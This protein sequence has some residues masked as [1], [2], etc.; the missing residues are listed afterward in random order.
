MKKFFAMLGIFVSNIFALSLILLI[1]F[2]AKAQAPLDSLFVQLEQAKDDTSKCKILYSIGWH[3]KDHDLVEGFVYADSALQL[4]KASNH[5]VTEIKTLSLLGVL[6]NRNGKIDDA[7]EYANQTYE[8]AEK[9]D[10]PVMM[11]SA[12][13]ELGNITS[14]IGDYAKSLEYFDRCLQMAEENG[15]KRVSM[16]ANLNKAKIYYTIAKLDEAI[17]SNFD[18]IKIAKELKNDLVLASAYLNCG[19]AYNAVEDYSQAIDMVTKA[20][21]LS[22]EIHYEM[23]RAE[24][25]NGLASIHNKKEDFKKGFDYAQEA[26]EIMREMNFVRGEIFCMQNLSVGLIGEGKIEEAIV[27]MNEEI[28]LCRKID[29]PYGVAT[30]LTNLGGA[31]MELGKPQLGKVYIDSA[32]ILATQI[33]ATV[34]LPDIYLNLYLVNDALKDYR[35]AL[36]YYRLYSELQ[37]SIRDVEMLREIGELKIKHEV[38]EKD[39]AIKLLEERDLRQALELE[40]SQERSKNSELK[41]SKKS[42]LIFG[43][44]AGIGLL[45]VLTILFGIRQRSRA[46]Y[47]MI[48]YERDKFEL[49]QKALRAQMNP[50][51]TFNTLN[52][53]QGYISEHNKEE[54]KHYLALFSSLMRSILINSERETISISEEVEV[55]EKYLSLEKMRFNSVFNY[56]IEIDDAIDADF[57]RIPPMLLQ[58]IVENSI[59]HGLFHKPEGGNIRISIQEGNNELVFTVEDDGIGVRAS[60]QIQATKE[61]KGTGKGLILIKELINRKGSGTKGTL[62]VEDLTNNKG[63]SLG[64]RV[65]LKIS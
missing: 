15:N 45:C 19:L 65:I 21:D 40:L 1:A 11:M 62:V 30:A 2:Q 43:L 51:F 13:N 63:E 48:Q 39:E 20:Y 27:W 3:Q 41:S 55:L 17:S 37:D 42:V 64:T 35:E 57:E 53:I 49:E 7:I 60:E 61:K 38:A 50:H 56:S 4:A 47:K 31:Y 36:K 14:N 23:G 26:I 28:K 6:S 16:F 22:S 24:S 46:K 8:L 18:V 54:A 32:E 59:N 44:V 9:H 25:L 10:R 33:G 5:H 34:M 58:P 52:S 12:L 29:D